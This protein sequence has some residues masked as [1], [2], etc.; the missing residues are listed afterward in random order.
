MLSNRKLELP[1]QMQIAR[2]YL[3]RQIATA[4]LLIG[5]IVVSAGCGFVYPPPALPD[6]IK[7]QVYNMGDPVALLTFAPGR[8]D[9]KIVGLLKGWPFPPLDP[10][11]GTPNNNFTYVGEFKVVARSSDDSMPAGAQGLRQIYFHEDMPQLS[12]ADTRTY[13]VGQE[14]AVDDI[15]LSFSFKDNHRVVAVRLITQ[16]KSALPFTYKGQKI[17]PPGKRDTSATLEGEYSAEYGGYV[18]S[19]LNE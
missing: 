5:A 16:Q 11:L 1:M 9:G 4:F 3:G 10:S 7:K 18:L 13:G 14:V 17:R 19:T 2:K 12:F 6:T 15:S 8:T